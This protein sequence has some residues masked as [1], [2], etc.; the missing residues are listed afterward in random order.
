MEV[1]E[2]VGEEVADEDAEV[3][4]VEV[5]ACGGEKRVNV[6]YILYRCR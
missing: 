4:E 2:F 3:E 6:K 5:C 1:I